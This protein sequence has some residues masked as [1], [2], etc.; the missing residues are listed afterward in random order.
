MENEVQ[1][2]NDGDG[3]ALIGDAN[4]IERFLAAEGLSSRKL[5]LPSFSQALGGASGALQA[6]SE[7]SAQSGRWVKLTEKS[8]T[9]LK[10]GKLMKGSDTGVSRAVLTQNGKISGLLE[11]VKTPAGFLTNPAVLAG[12]AGVMAQLAMQ[13]TMEEITAYLKTIDEKCDDILRAQKDDV[14]A[15]MVGVGMEIDEATTIREAVGRVT[16]VTWSKVQGSSQ[17]ISHT[18]AYALQQI[19]ALVSKLEKKSNVGEQAKASKETEH[20]VREWLVV[21]ARC[22]Q[23]KDA[24]GVLELDR[25]LDAEP[26]ELDKHRRAL[27]LAREKRLNIIS[28]STTQLIDRLNSAAGSANTKKLLRPF[29][30]SKVVHSNNGAI[31]VLDAFHES[32]GIEAGHDFV[33]AKRWV[34]AVDET[35][36][37]VVVATADGF[38]ATKRFSGE[39][40]DN[41]KSVTIKVSADVKSRIRRQGK[42][43]E[44]QEHDD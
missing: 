24:L 4:A 25:V 6:G 18:Q 22:V 42:D 43:D 44:V 3:V 28:A 9:A 36:D 34:E 12:A 20:K 5:E 21:L 1:L 16:E 8:A 35:R 39:A 13:Q 10:Q 15:D 2:I 23:L 29:S 30:S 33:N 32:L 40:I 17:T 7:I 11:I 31:T 38:D 37:K 19:D 27:K 26:Q 14:V 41:V